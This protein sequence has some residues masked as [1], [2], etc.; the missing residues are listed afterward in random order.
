LA[1]LIPIP[2]GIGVTEGGLTYGLVAAGMDQEA[3]FAAVILYRIATFYVPPTWG[4]FA[5]R[6]LE[7][8]QQI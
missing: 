3:A 7:R 5:L 6:W 8:N 2:G 1:G 4:Y